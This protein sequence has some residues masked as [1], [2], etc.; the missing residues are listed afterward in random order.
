[1]LRYLETVKLYFY[2]KDLCRRNGNEIL[3]EK[4]NTFAIV[5]SA[6]RLF[7][8]SRAGIILLYQ[9]TN[10]INK[11]ST[12]SIKAIDCARYYYTDDKS[13]FPNRLEDSI[14]GSRVY[15]VISGK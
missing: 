11:L 8:L 15:R 4:V 10:S 12:L 2:N 9:L 6:C 3:I 1:M 13:V 14:N 5:K 7:Y